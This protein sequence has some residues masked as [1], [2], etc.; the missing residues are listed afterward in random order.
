MTRL[1]RARRNGTAKRGS[2]G[3]LAVAAAA[4][5]A[6]SGCGGGPSTSANNGP[7]NAGPALSQAIAPDKWVSNSSDFKEAANWDSAKEVSVTLGAGTLTP[8]NLELVAGQPYVIDIKNADTVD[9]G[10]SAPEFMRASATRKVESPS[11]EIKMKLINA[12]YVHSGKSMPIFIVP[13]LPGVTKMEGLTNG[14]PAAGMT[15]TISVTGAAPTKPAPVIENLST[16]GEVADA[17]GLVKAALPA[18]GTAASVTIEMGDNEEVH[19]FKPKLTTLKLGVPVVLTFVNKGNVLHEY[20]ATDLF[21]TMAVWKISNA[22][23]WV[24]GAV[25]RPADLEA[26]GQTSLYVIPTKSGTFTLGDSTPGM[27]S[28]A[29]TIEVVA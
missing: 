12:I 15:G 13:V 29:A 2:V 21:T 6:F 25:V 18:W 4:L 3:V 1:V 17:A 24:E 22:E 28:M 20:D 5:V 19:F 26:G 14:S 23:G 11:S 10:W 7:G 9:H 27:E 16:V 8:S